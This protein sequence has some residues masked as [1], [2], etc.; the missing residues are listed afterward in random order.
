[1]L[2]VIGKRLLMLIPTLIGLSILLFLWVRNLPGGPA[3]A[4]LGDKASPEA[5]ANINK[6]YGF[7]R[8][9]IE[10]YFTYVG[11]LLKGDFGTSIVTGR[12]VLEEF[13][14]RFPATVELAVVALIFAIGIGIPLG[15]LAARHY[16][17][18]WDHS[19][20]VLSLIGITVPVFFLAF[21]LKWVLAI[22]LGWFPTDGRQDPRINATHVTDFFV[23]DGLLTREWDASWDAILHLVLPAIA[24]GTI[25]LAIIVRITRAS[26]LEVQGAD[27]VRTARAKGLMEKTIRGRFILRNAM[28]PVTTTIGLQTGLLISGAVLTETVFAFSGIGKFLRDAIFA[29]DYPVLQGFI[30]FIAVAYS[31]INLLVDVSYGFIDPRVRVQ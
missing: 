21:I 23:L 6:A 11:K 24:L 15:Y 8:P 27:Y 9:L 4:L 29:L 28:L 19:S 2:R 22:Q 30:V 17:R 14:T 12:S 13:G 16:G 18:F 25:P 26:V 3:T 1:M 10:Q 5:I 20:V 31:L 7:D